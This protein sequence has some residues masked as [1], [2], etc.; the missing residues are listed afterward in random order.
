MRMRKV[1][2]TDHN[3]I[4][5]LGFD[6]E[7][8]FKSLLS[9]RCGITEIKNDDGKIFYSSIVD[10]EKL[11]LEFLKIGDVEKYTTLEKMMILSVEKIIVTSKVP[12]SENTG[13]IIATTK[14]NVDTLSPR[15]KFHKDKKRVYLNALGKT[16]QDFFKFKNEA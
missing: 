3:I 14:G 4:S 10:K 15:S 8:N 6:S 2:I 7:T 12:T 11:N 16:V 1:Y 9:N 5:S 13:L